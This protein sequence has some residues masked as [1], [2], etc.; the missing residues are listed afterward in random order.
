M[1]LTNVYLI[2]KPMKDLSKQMFQI[3]FRMLP[4]HNGIDKVNKILKS[5]LSGQGHTPDKD[6]SW[7]YR[8]NSSSISMNHETHSSESGIFFFII[9]NISQRSAPRADKLTKLWG[10]LP[11]AMKPKSTQRDTSI[12]QQCFW[13][14]TATD[15][16]QRGQN[17]WN[18][19]LHTR[20]NYN[21]DFT[22]C[23]ACIITNRDKF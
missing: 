23:P 18:K 10:D 11:S 15:F 1:T 9:A 22:N 4:R 17:S 21:C 13:L 20:A 16:N 2:F 19:T 3:F 14:R 8:Y 5:G 12:F 6:R 7:T